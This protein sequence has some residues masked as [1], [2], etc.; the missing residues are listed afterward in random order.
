MDWTTLLEVGGIN[1]FVLAFT[2]FI[3]LTVAKNGA[4]LKTK[5]LQLLTDQLDRN[6]SNLD[7]LAATVVELSAQ[8]TLIS[9]L[10]TEILVICT[11]LETEQKR[12]KEENK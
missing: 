8:V 3:V 5:L 10:L 7:V 12:L 2:M 11:H 1:L 6:N 9:T 4:Q